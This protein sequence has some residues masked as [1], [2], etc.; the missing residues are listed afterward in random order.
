MLN[1]YPLW[2]PSYPEHCCA[3]F[4]LRFGEPLC[5]D[6]AVQISGASSS[7]EINQRDIT[8]ATKALD[9]QGIEH[10]GEEFT[11][12]SGLIA[13]AARMINYQRKKRLKVC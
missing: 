8:K 2:K 10:F 9:A 1:R 7:L 13:S 11:A 5:A 6:P 12:K 4:S 3:R